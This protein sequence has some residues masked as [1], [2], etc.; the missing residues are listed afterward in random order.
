[1]KLRELDESQQLL[2]KGIRS[3]DFRVA[4]RISVAVAAVVAVATAE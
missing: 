2:S 4:G 1:M 3:V